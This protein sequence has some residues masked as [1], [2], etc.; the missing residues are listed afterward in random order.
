[1]T[2]SPFLCLFNS[3]RRLHNYDFFSI[4]GIMFNKLW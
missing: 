3:V 4:K 2:A 1:M